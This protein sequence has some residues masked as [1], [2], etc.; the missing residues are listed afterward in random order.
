MTTRTDS[1]TQPL[2]S[3][4]LLT[5]EPDEMAALQR[6]FEAAPRYFDVVTGL[7][8]GSAEAQST[9][10]ALPPGSDY[11]HKRVWG[12]YAGEEMIGCADVVR[13]YPIRE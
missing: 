11:E 7:P 4:R 13:G 3:L 2:L 8:P 1:S 10:T 12:L 6:V 5:G 9:F